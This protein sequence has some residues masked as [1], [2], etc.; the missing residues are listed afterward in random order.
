MKR[1]NIVLVSLASA[2]VAMAADVTITSGQLSSLINDGSLQSEVS[3][4]LTG[5]IDARDLAAIEKL[6][7]SIKTL[8]LS[9]TTI[10]GLVMSSREYFGRSLF[11]E[12][13]IPAY[14]FFKSP[15]ETLLLPAQ[16]SAIGEGAFAASQ[17]K[18]IIIP[19]GVTAISDYAFYGCPAL[20]SI[21]LPATLTSLGKGSFGNCTSLK[22][23]SLAG[24]QIEEIPERA[25]AGAVQLNSIVLPADLR[26]VGRE[27]FSHTMLANLDLSNVVEFEPFALSGMPYLENLSINSKATMPVGLLMD[28]TSL[29]SLTGAPEIIPDY[30]AANCTSL[31]TQTAVTNAITMGKYAFANNTIEELILSPGLRSLDQGV[32]SGMTN[33][34]R[35]DASS[36]K[37]E[38]PEV[39]ET[40]F[41]GIVQENVILYVTDDDFHLWKADPV[42]RLF[43]LMSDTKVGVDNP[44]APVESGIT[45]ALRGNMLVMESPEYIND[46]RIYTTDGRMLFTANPVDTRFELATDNF[47]SGV[48]VVVA[49]DAAGNKKNVSILR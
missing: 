11:K 28:D 49:G 19:E 37:G 2:S 27:A 42:W 15:I 18:S 10:D 22:Q 16:V 47:P 13:E 39:D 14:T 7:E 30:F 35:I 34:K 33:L 6:P 24:T 3:L 26:K 21:S 41:E 46:V 5:H 4:K 44:V 43:F 20:E 1:I 40:T 25:F 29:I 9:A 8:D 12:G 31:D 23:I 45:I 17:L 38:I 32:I 36:L 48:L